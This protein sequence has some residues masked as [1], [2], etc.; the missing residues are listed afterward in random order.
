[1]NK[2][3]RRLAMAF[4]GISM[5]VGVGVAVGASREAMRVDATVGSDVTI[6]DGTYESVY[7][8]GFE[9]ATAGTTY[10]STQTY[11]STVGDG[12]AW[13]VYYGTVSTNAKITGSKSMQM[14]WY[15][16]AKTNYP[17]AETTSYISNVKAIKFN[18]AVGN[19]NVDFKV[20][21]GTD[22]SNWTDIET[23][24]T[25]GTTA[26]EYSHEFSS[27][28][29]TFYFRVL[30]CDGTAPTSGNYTFRIDDIVFGKAK[31][32]ATLSSI[33]VSTAPNKTLYV[34]GE[35]FDPTGLVITR[36]YSDSTSDTYTYA[37]HTSDFTFSP[38]TSTALTTSHTSVTITYG[39][40]TT[41]QAITVKELSSI[42]VTTPPTKTVYDVGESFD[43]TGMVVTATYSDSSTADVTSS[44]TFTPNSLTY[45]TTEVTVSY[46]GKTTTQAVTVNKV[47]SVTFTAGTDT[48]TSGG[49]NA[50]SITKS[51]ITFS[52]TSMATT[53]AEYRL[54]ASS[55]VTFTSTIGKMSSIQFT[56]NGS[57]S[58]SLI[59][60]NDDNGE[61]NS[62]T[63]LWEG[64][65][66]SVSFT[67][68]AQFRADAIQV[69]IASPVV[70]LN[71]ASVNVEKDGE[72]TSVVATAK[73]FSG[74]PTITAST[75]SG[76]IAVE[77]TSGHLEILAGSTTGEAT[78]TITAT[79]STEVANVNLTVYVIEASVPVTNIAVSKA[80]NNDLYIGQT[81]QLTATVTP[82]NATDGTVTW[83]SSSDSVATV[84]STGLVTAAG[85][86]SVTITATANDGSGV[87]GTASVTVVA[88]PTFTEVTSTDKL[89]NGMTVVI[90]SKAGT[91]LLSTTQNSNNRGTVSSTINNSVITPSALGFAELTLGIEEMDNGTIVYSFYDPANSGYLY[92]ANSS[93]NYMRTEATLDNNGRFSLS[94]E[95]GEAT[96]L[97]QG[98]YTHNYVRFNSTLFSCYAEDSS[99]GTA[100]SLFAKTGQ[101]VTDAQKI[102]TFIAKNM[103]MNSYDKGGDEGSTAGDGSCTTY[104]STAKAAFNSNTLMSD[105]A[106]NTFCSDNTYLAA[107]KRLS[108]WATA[109][110][111]SFNNSTHVLEAN[112]NGISVS[113]N[114]YISDSA[115]LIIAV[116]SIISLTAV[117][118][119]FVIRRRKENN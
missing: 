44:C 64:E 28:I 37:N 102:E 68:S 116:I 99:T 54:Y 45:G 12:A 93:S 46:G 30:V 51:G 25:S 101:T 85:V 82:D 63:G 109:N 87:Y 77:Y 72:D 5:A 23:V 27:A 100:V 16:S 111:D 40:K 114:N 66:V 69:N 88:F 84:N 112:H 10:N 33:S 56:K 43:N 8:T 38:T 55:T 59:S 91:N 20:Q 35:Y 15:S 79:Y 76:L 94:I 18:Y 13:S 60:V 89:F 61:Y 78:V 14:R 34:A 96:L 2:L 90:A 7:E 24:N 39:G 81:V 57:Y 53:T 106:R 97:A 95:E 118:G 110:N 73:F 21:Y 3:I 115:V 104:Y 103:K 71:K 36:T 22:G 1:M 113:I 42:A 107:Y 67:L 105:S 80:H 117:G 48:G 86:G 98:T 70:T 49:Q 62:S 29:S 32:S 74:T 75:E 19:A 108:A 50:D 26:T 92:A 47:S 52:G 83:S 65:T 41:S 17:H 119:Y 31:S 4:V 9:N 11:N 58:Y 6:G